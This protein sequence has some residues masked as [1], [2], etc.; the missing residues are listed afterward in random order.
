MT[1][2]AQSGKP[3]S[4]LTS[5]QHFSETDSLSIFQLIDSLLKIP[6][7]GETG[8]SLVTRLGYNSNVLSLN[9]GIAANQFSLSPGI[10]YYHNSGLYLDATTYWSQE[11]NP[12]VFLSIPS[13]GYLKS[14]KKWTLNLEYSHFFYTYNSD[15]Y[16]SPFTNSISSSNFFNVKPFLFRLD[17][18]FYFGQMDGH[19]ITPAISLN[20]KKKN[21]LGISQIFFYP[22]F[23]VQLGNDSW[24]D[25]KLYPNPVLRYLKGMPLYYLKNYNEFGVLNYYVSVPL[26]LSIHSWT[27]Q[28]NYTY[29]F[30][31]SLPGET[32]TFTNYGS[33]SFNVIRYFNFKIKNSAIDFY[34]LPK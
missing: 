7:V 12:S 13:F 9:S 25:Y 2:S 6:E 26:S 27:F 3:I 32:L 5:N 31:Q 18:S 14:V 1:T 23:A 20:L 30:I 10:T 29:N 22:T 15:G 33:L 19:R 24:Q 34:K 17:Y 28:A 8:S 16:G 4:A 11:Y 21:W